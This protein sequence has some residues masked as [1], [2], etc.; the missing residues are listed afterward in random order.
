[1]KSKNL[2]KPPPYSSKYSFFHARNVP[3]AYSST[4]SPTR[5]QSF[6]PPCQSPAH[7]LSCTSGILIASC[8]F[9][10]FKRPYNIWNNNCRL[11]ASQT[12]QCWGPCPL[13]PAHTPSP[14]DRFTPAKIKGD[15]RLYP[16]SSPGQRFALKCTNQGRSGICLCIFTQ[17]VYRSHWN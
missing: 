4:P 11:Q 14:G 10:N 16:P 12:L 8:F 3:I 13:E 6:F 9:F 17:S 5:P 2:L 1:M 15:P 7:P